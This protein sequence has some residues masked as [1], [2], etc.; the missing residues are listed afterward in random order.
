MYLNVSKEQKK[1]LDV[2]WIPSED[3]VAILKGVEILMEKEKS[4]KFTSIILSK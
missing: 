4:N 3:D 2:L 1:K